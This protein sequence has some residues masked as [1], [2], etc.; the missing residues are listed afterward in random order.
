MIDSDELEESF[1]FHLQKDDHKKP[2]SGL[3]FPSEVTGCSLKVF[4]NRMTR[5]E[6]LINSFLF[7]GS[8]VHFYL[9]ESGLL[10]DILHDAGYHVL[11]TKYEVSNQ[12]EIDDGVRI[13]GSC[14]VLCNSD[15]GTIIFD[16]KYSSLT[17]GSRH[18]RIYKYQAQANTY[19]YLFDADAYGLIMIPSMEGDGETFLDNINVLPA[20]KSE[21]NWNIVKEKTKRIHNT[22]QDAGYDQDKVWDTEFLASR[23][24]K[25]WK[26]VISRFD[27]K[28]IPA[29]QK[30]CDYC[31]HSDYC[32]V[33]NNKV[34]SGLGNVIS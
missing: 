18:G 2:E 32:P 9:Q 33:Y 12:K 10:D 24:T 25:F 15:E 29:Y 5:A 20:E 30:E 1:K 17:L 13:H 22:L 4:L 14:D 31:D 7:Q 27:L 34:G 26:E 19:A 23:S 28:N 6:V 8:A 11:D 3:F 21:D 16:L